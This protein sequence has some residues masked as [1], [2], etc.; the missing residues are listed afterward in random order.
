MKTARAP[1]PV[2]KIPG[3][4]KLQ[5]KMH[6]ALR[7]QHPEWVEADGRS[8]MCDYYESLFAT[9]LVSHQAHARTH[10]DDFLSVIKAEHL[11]ATANSSIPVG[12]AECTPG[13]FRTVLAPRGS[14]KP[15]WLS[16]PK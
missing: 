6:D 3:Y 12:Y 4:S 1:I 2:P 11:S 9:L 7:A 14:S 15:E 8:P 16:N 10:Y 5:R 13:F